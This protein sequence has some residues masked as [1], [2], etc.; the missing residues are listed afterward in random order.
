MHQSKKALHNKE[1]GKNIYR[2]TQ[3]KKGNCPA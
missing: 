1:K 3:I 2:Q